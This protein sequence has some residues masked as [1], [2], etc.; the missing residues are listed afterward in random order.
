MKNLAILLLSTIS[1]HVSAQPYDIEATLRELDHVVHKHSY[2]VELHQKKIDQVK[3]DLRFAQFDND[4]YIINKKLYALY[5]KFDGDSAI[6]YAL[7]NFQLGLKNKNIGWQKEAE[8]NI[9]QIQVIR[10]VLFLVV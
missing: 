1:I 9:A 2:Y 5:K 8:L 6:T 10:G 3:K 7:R 4:R